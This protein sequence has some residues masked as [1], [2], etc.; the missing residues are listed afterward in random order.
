MYEAKEVGPGKLSL[1]GPGLKEGSWIIETTESPMLIA[2]L[3]NGAY[4]QGEKSK[5]FEVL[6]ELVTYAKKKDQ[7]FLNALDD[8]SMQIGSD[9]GAMTRLKIIAQGIRL[10]FFS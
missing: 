1:S 10:K 7:N 6:E 5:P 3:L 4:K 9:K 8:I 2:S